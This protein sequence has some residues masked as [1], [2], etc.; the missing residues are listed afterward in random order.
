MP[1][2]AALRTPGDLKGAPDS[3]SA[4]SNHTS[5]S[6]TLHSFSNTAPYQPLLLHRVPSPSLGEMLELW[7]PNPYQTSFTT[8]REDNVNH[9]SP[10]NPPRESITTLVDFGD[11][12]SGQTQSRPSSSLLPAPQVHRQALFQG[13]AD[14]VEC[15][16]PSTKPSSRGLDN[17]STRFGLCAQLA[18]ISFE[19]DT[20]QEGPLSP[21]PSLVR[22]S[23]STCPPAGIGGESPTATITVSLD[24]SDLLPLRFASMGMEHGYFTGSQSTRTSKQGVQFSSERSIGAPF[25][26]PV[27]IQDGSY[28]Q[29]VFMPNTTDWKCDLAYP[30]QDGPGTRVHDT[31]SSKPVN[32]TS[33]IDWDD[34]ETDK[35]GYRSRLARVKKSFTDLR[36]AERFI[37]DANAK[38]E[39]NGVTKPKQE[40]VDFDEPSTRNILALSKPHRTPRQAFGEFRYGTYPSASGSKA[41]GLRKRPSDLGLSPGIQIAGQ[42]NDHGRPTGSGWEPTSLVSAHQGVKSRVRPGTSTVLSSIGKRKRASDMS[43]STGSGEKKARLSIMGKLMK[44]VLWRHH[45]K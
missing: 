6:S 17:T 14:R 20:P 3:G 24:P 9:G 38:T 30:G 44:R 19:C 1:P 33:Y 21:V 45:E 36:A 8:G 7:P 11:W 2:E 27:S 13:D 34:D 28:G 26:S 22:S 23:Q 5:T 40:H 29:G 10:Q 41:V 25:P 32:E 15:R 31:L 35:Q 42:G 39:R 4:H 12:V 43:K 37:T 16:L 18:D